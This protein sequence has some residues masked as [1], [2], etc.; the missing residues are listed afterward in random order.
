MAGEQANRSASKATISDSDYGAQGVCVADKIYFDI[1]F[2]QKDSAKAAGLRWDSAARKWYASSAEIA[3]ASAWP[4]ATCV[5]ETEQAN[6]HYFKVPF[7]Q[8]DRAKAMGMRFDGTR[9]LWFAPSSALAVDATRIFERIVASM[10]D[11]D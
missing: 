5:G 6:R 4:V 8:K 10:E 9:K 3:S 7:L 2:E 1:P 11:N